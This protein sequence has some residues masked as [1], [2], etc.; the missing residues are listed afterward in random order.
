MRSQRLASSKSPFWGIKSSP[1][2]TP[3]CRCC[4]KG[5]ILAVTLIITKVVVIYPCYGA[6]IHHSLI[7]SSKPC[8]HLLYPFLPM[9][10]FHL[11]PPSP[12]GPSPTLRSTPAFFAACLRAAA[13]ASGLMPPALLST[14]MPK[15]ES[16]GVRRMLASGEYRGQK[17]GKKKGGNAEK[18]T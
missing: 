16:R 8:F 17:G 5:M 6:L 10:C 2:T 15:G 12:S 9:P 7:Y 18:C 14:R 3:T 11:L 13:Q 1:V 4:N